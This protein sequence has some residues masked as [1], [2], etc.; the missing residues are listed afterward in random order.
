[1]RVS[2]LWRHSS[3]WQLGIGVATS[4]GMVSSGHLGPIGQIRWGDR[5]LEMA[6]WVA[7]VTG[8]VLFA[9][10]SVAVVALT[11][12]SS[13]ETTHL[14]D[15]TTT[16]DHDESVLP[17]DAP[18]SDLPA[19]IS[20]TDT[21]ASQLALVQTD[22]GE[23]TWRALHLEALA[24]SPT[25]ADSSTTA[26]D[27]GSQLQ[28]ALERASVR[29]LSDAAIRLS[30]DDG[31]WT[32]TLIRPSGDTVATAA[33]EFDDLETVATAVSQLKDRGPDGTRIDIGSGAFTL[34]ER[35]ERWYWRLVDD[36]RTP[37]AVSPDGTLHRDE[38]AATA[39]TVGSLLA[40]ARC[41]DAE[42]GAV[43][44]HRSEDGPGRWTWRLLDSQATELLTATATFDDRTGAEA[45]ATTALE[46]IESAA[47]L[48]VD[49]CAYDCYPDAGVWQWRLVDDTDQVVARGATA[50][51][52]HEQTRQAINHFRNAIPDATITDF[53]DAVYEIHPAGA[54]LER[55]TASDRT[56]QSETADRSG[57]DSVDSVAAAGQWNWRLVTDDRTCLAVSP[58]PSADA[59]RA[60]AQLD[61]LREQGHNATLCS[62]ETAAFRVYQS[63]NG[64]WRWRLLDAGGTVLDDSDAAHDSRN[65]AIEAMLTLK[66]RAPDAAV[67]EVETATFELYTVGEEWSWRLLDD[68]G[69][70]VATAP[71]RYPSVD[72]AREAADRV[73]T[74]S[75]AD[76]VT[77]DRA[78]FQP[79]TNCDGDD[80]TTRTDEPT[81][82]ATEA[83]TAAE[84][85]RWHWRVVHPSGELLAVSGRGF[86]TRDA[87]LE[88]IDELREVAM[89]EQVETT[90]P[91]TVQLVGEE[92]CRFRLINRNRT[93]IA[94][95]T[96]T[97][98]TRERARTAIAAL[99]RTTSSVPVFTIDDAVIWLERAADG[100]DG[101]SDSASDEADGANVAVET[102]TESGDGH[103]STW[104]WTLLDADRTVLARSPTQTTKTA[105]QTQIDRMRRLAPHASPVALTGVSF[106]L[107]EAPDSGSGPP[108]A[109]DDA[110]DHTDEITRAGWQWR[111]LE[112]NGDPVAVD[113]RPGGS[114]ADV[115]ERVASIQKLLAA[116][117]VITLEE[118]VIELYGDEEWAWRL[119]DTTGDPVLESTQT[120]PTRQ[121]VTDAIATMQSRVP[122]GE[123]TVVDDDSN[124]ESG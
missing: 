7:I 82:T 25:S 109:A 46:G 83:G 48:A 69:M 1:M 13:T 51:H 41:I 92:S 102:A 26:V 91:V 5:G 31:D 14:E 3:A 84:T 52:S 96:R 110:S 49:Q 106:D 58:E 119:I 104:R 86:A 36:E 42:T 15:S 94:E 19:V 66:E 45:A 85:P 18:T 63:E 88:Q 6:P 20:G 75:S 76:S 107:V 60:R 65:E 56:T 122:T 79:Y 71:T 22:H 47:V 120:Y 40:D 101:A 37:L 108:T 27:Q 74:H 34:T 93:P 80:G 53:E 2:Q 68:A 29:E 113:A 117:D 10:V 23:W 50:R 111:L 61:R 121:A 105:L 90:G 4:L 43:E 78:T 57:D 33:S 21:A 100:D 89:T 99:E 115:H 73:Q 16:A 72:A 123:I 59:G 64:E 30:N 81:P 95:S 98:E 77:M 17:T 70:L 35:D 12:Q 24:E 103:D 124:S 112:A 116:A 8:V 54:V 62:F 38:A 9:G 39:E 28:T 97:Y 114:K 87:L 118:P 32:W 55:D 67:V 11:R 44:L